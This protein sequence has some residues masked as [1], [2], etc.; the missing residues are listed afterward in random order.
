M[1]TGK[2]KEEASGKKMNLEASFYTH[3]RVRKIV[4]FP[5]YPYVQFQDITV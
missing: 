4:K 3:R 2:K 1:V 5:M